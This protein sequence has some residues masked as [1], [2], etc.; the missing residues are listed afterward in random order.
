MKL[1]SQTTNSTISA[2]KSLL[3]IF[4]SLGIIIKEVYSVLMTLAK[5]LALVGFLLA[6]PS[7][8]VFIKTMATLVAI[9][10][11]LVLVIQHASVAIQRLVATL[12]LGV[13]LLYKNLKGIGVLIAALGAM[14]PNLA[15]FIHSI[16]AAK[17]AIVGLMLVLATMSNGAA[18]L[19]TRAGKLGV[20]FFFVASQLTTNSGALVVAFGA[21]YL[22]AT[23][24]NLVMS[25]G[26]FGGKTGIFKWIFLLNVGFTTLLS[27]IGL[28]Y[29]SFDM[30]SE[31]KFIES[32][33]I[34]KWI[35]T[36]G[37]A[38]KNLFMEFSGI[39]KLKEVLGFDEPAVKPVQ[40]TIDKKQIQNTVQELNNSKLFSFMG[41]IKVTP[42]NVVVG[43]NQKQQSGL[44]RTDQYMYD[45]HT[46]NKQRVE[47]NERSR[48]VSDYESAAKT[49]REINNLLKSGTLSD[50]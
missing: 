24:V 36:I 15:T 14:L 23:Q 35:E 25:S 42:E 44:S 33:E 9:A 49:R 38:A 30:F 43:D 50:K 2:T 7:L 28:V 31:L 41:S 40:I 10:A 34:Q 27:V 26:F 1:V 20:A 48:V 4:S 6:A 16:D 3:G 21:L 13:L 11:A 18:L 39:N 17:G 8:F 12:S 45:L 46:T 32:E 37:L 5:G 22:M 19:A 29:S 47:A